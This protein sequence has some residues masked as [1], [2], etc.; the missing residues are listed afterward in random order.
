MQRRY[1]F[2]AT[3]AAGQ[4]F[5]YQDLYFGEGGLIDIFRKPAREFLWKLYKKQVANGVSGWWS[6]LGEPEKHPNTIMHNLKDQGISRPVSAD[7]IHNLYGHQWS[8]M[9]Y[10]KYR[11]DFPDQ[12]LFHLNRAG[13]AGSQR[14]S[15]FPWTGDVARSWSGLKAQWPVLMGMSL[16]RPSLCAFRC[17]WIC[18]GRAG[19]CG[20]LH[21]MVAVRCIH[22]HLPAAWHGTGRLR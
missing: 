5:T 7:E 11:D 9:L 14:Y 8:A 20:A 15:V 3:D 18:D 12:R 13:F 16:Q 4:P 19:R 2:L 17:R 10:E 21:P 6:D 1:P 22:A